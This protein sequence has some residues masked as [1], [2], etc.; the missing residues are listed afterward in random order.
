MHTYMHIRIDRY[1]SRYIY[2]YIYG[3]SV[4]CRAGDKD[5]KA[6][7]DTYDTRTSH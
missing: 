5:G 2:T 6:T 4:T 1:T 7:P 3:Y